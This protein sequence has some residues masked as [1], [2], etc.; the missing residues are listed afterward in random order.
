M[1]QMVDL[2]EGKIQPSS[3]TLV[4]SS[5]VYHVQYTQTHDKPQSIFAAL[6]YP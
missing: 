1:Q 2:I 4:S 3:A 6:A 5:E